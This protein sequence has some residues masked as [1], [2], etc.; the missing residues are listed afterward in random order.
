[1]VGKAL[2]KSVGV[3]KFTRPPKAALGDMLQSCAVILGIKRDS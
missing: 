3:P 2:N 1:M